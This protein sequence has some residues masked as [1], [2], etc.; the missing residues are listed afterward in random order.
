MYHFANDIETSCE[1]AFN[2]KREKK[3][4]KASAIDGTGYSATM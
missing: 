4:N 2:K 1:T 3:N